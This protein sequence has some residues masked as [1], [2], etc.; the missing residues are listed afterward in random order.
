MKHKVKG[1]MTVYFSITITAIVLLFCVLFRISR[2]FIIQAGGRQ[3]LDF[4]AS[5]TLGGY[6]R[7]LQENYGLY[8][9]ASVDQVHEDIEFYLK[10]NLDMKEIKVSSDIMLTHEKVYKEQIAQY[11]Q[12]RFFVSLITQYTEIFDTLK[13]AQSD[14]DAV[15][16]EVDTTGVLS[17]YNQVFA[18]FITVLEGIEENGARKEP[19][20]KGFWN[21]NWQKNVYETILTE[22][23]QDKILHKGAITSWM[24][25][26]KSYKSTAEEAVRLWK[27]VCEEGSKARSELL[28]MQEQAA[29]ESA[30]EQIQAMI[31]EIHTGDTADLNILEGLQNN[32]QYMEKALEGLDNLLDTPKAPYNITKA[33]VLLRYT[34]NIY[35][36]FELR[37]SQEKRSWRRLWNEMQDYVTDLSMYV[38][39]EKPYDDNIKKT[40]PS[41]VIKEESDDGISMY[42]LPQSIENA[43]GNTSIISLNRF[44]NV[45]YLTGLFWNL[46]EIIQ[47]EKGEEIKNMNGKEKTEGVFK[48]E[49]EYVICGKRSDLANCRGVRLR[50]IGVRMMCNLLH[51][52]TDAEKQ[53]TIKSTAALTGGIVAPGIGNLIMEGLIISVWAG[54]ESYADYEELIDG[55][56]V[57]LVKNNK[58]WI[59]DL[60]RVWDKPWKESNKKE[61]GK[62]EEDE[63]DGLAYVDYLKLLLLLMSQEKVEQRTQDLIQLN[64]QKITGT[65]I[66]LSEMPVQFSVEGCFEADGREYTLKGEYGY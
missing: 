12:F 25:H 63:D 33:K 28:K 8:A 30:K 2:I 52:M 44:Y 1:S 64:M 54:V 49:V 35:V 36:D 6:S 18:E 34:E 38:T 29:S 48:A 37:A 11:M 17:E 59:T 32:D 50:I 7:E 24:D 46:S 19:S 39:D 15:K 47:K 16:E 61:E 21:D 31:Q 43:I 3:T 55:R 27:K 56:R 53:K 57:P 45:E 58:E 60:D 40:L 14:R 13:K 9:I 5:S 66:Y 23:E 65:D 51:L 42:S 26:I 62:K 4:C 41:A 20:V 22:A 10:S